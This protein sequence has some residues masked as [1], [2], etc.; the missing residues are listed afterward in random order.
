LIGFSLQLKAQ[1]NYL[2][3]GF[4]TSITTYTDLGTGGT[5]ISVSNTDDG[6]SAALPIGFTFNFNGASYDSFTF[7]TNGFI[8]LGRDTASRQFLF[9]SHAQPPANGPFTAATSPVPTGS[10]SSFIFAFGQDLIPLNPSD[11]YRYEVSGFPGTQVCTIQWK[12]VKDKLQ[13]SV[14]GLW[15][16]INFQVKLYEGTNVI[17]VVYG[18]WRSTSSISA[19]RFSAVGLVGRSMTVANQNLHLVKGSTVAWGG[20]VANTGFYLNNAVNYRNPTS[21][22]AGPA[23]E[24]GRT[25]TFTPLMLNDASVR[26]VYAQGK[27]ALP[28]YRADSIRANIANTGINTLTGLVVTLTISGANTYTT[29]ATIGSLAPNANTNVSFAPYYPTNLGASLITVSVPT[30]DNPANNNRTYSFSV[31]EHIHSYIDTLVPSSGGNGT[32]IPNFWGAR[33]FIEGS[34]MVTQVRSPLAS[35]SDAVNDTVCGLVLD[36]TG[37]ILAK[38]PSYIVQS[39]DLGTTLVFNMTMPAVVSNQSVIVGI[40]GGQSVN[41][42]NYFLGTSQTEVPI[43]PDVSFY[44]MTQTFPGGVSSLNVGNV[45]ANPVGWGTTRLMMECKVDPLPPID[46]G[47]SA[48]GPNAAVKVPT[49]VAIPL[50]AVIKNFGTQLRPNGIQVRYQVNGGAVVGPVLSSSPINPGDTTSVLFAGTSALNFGS[51]GNYTVKIFTSLAGDGLIGNDTLTVVYQAQAAQTL[52]FLAANN[53]L[54]SFTTLNNTPAIWKQGTAIQANGIGNSLVTFADNISSV[55]GREAWLLS[56]PISLVG[57]VNPVLHFQLAHGPNTFAGTDDTLEVL[58]STNGG[59]TYTSLYSKSSQ[60]SAPSLGT[61]T[62]T[63]L[64]YVPNFAQDWR[65]ESV[66]L[67]L[68]AGAPYITLAFKNRCASGNS[69]YIGGLSIANAANTNNQSVSFAS[70]FYNSELSI[71][72]SSIGNAS[73][74][75][76]MSRHAVAPYTSASPVFAT[77]TSATTNNASVFTPSNASITH[78]YS[79]AYSGIGT[80]NYSPSVSYSINIDI[81]NIPGITS[82]DSLYI[83]RRSDFSGSWQ[84]VSTSVSGVNLYTGLISGFGDIGIGS[85]PSRNVLPVTW[86]QFNASKKDAFTNALL[87][88]TSNEINSDYFEVEYSPDG[89]SFETLG[90]VNA[91]GN[92]KRVQTYVYDHSIGRNAAEI[93]YYRI[94]QIDTDGAFS[95]SK[96]IQLGSDQNKE[97]EINVSNPFSKNVSIGLNQNEAAELLIRVMDGQGKIVLEKNYTAPA[98]YSGIAL[99]ELDGK[100]AGFYYLEISRNNEIVYQR[101]LVKTND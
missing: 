4:S 79:L 58:V 85:V 77:N 91:A 23:P 12:N 67:S 95:Y 69:I 31:G 21:T 88:K 99:N 78:W 94:K 22:P 75:I 36:S 97:P 59:L 18:K 19:A 45:Y 16:T 40:A 1:L 96:T 2:P 53:L 68:F 34:G 101:K 63:S 89:S 5:A 66:N 72:F 27:V 81:T 28:Y 62:P 42:L 92:S 29:T 44:F 24:L 60:L 20:A 55:S 32:T 80:G 51:A 61:D 17:E 65:Y 13:A 82:T 30:D 90:R 76:S 41:G 9:T 43:R 71:T 86:L 11:A 7:S 38:S 25:Y 70:S 14:A 50:R 39:S 74:S 8:K 35:N 83:I 6:F 73:G 3:G 49:N 57:A 46:V 47:I 37:R 48:S 54:S 33:Y 10:D 15:D 64:I 93:A 100:S 52:P 84:A 98:G 26:A 87:W 56:P